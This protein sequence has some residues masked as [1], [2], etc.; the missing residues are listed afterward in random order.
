MRDLDRA[1]PA[2]ARTDAVPAADQRAGLLG[3]APDLQRVGAGENEVVRQG[4]RLPGLDDDR[5][6]GR[7]RRGNDQQ[8]AGERGAGERHRLYL[9]GWG[10]IRASG[11]A[12]AASGPRVADSEG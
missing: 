4:V 9:G 10:A 1:G 5:G 2:V 3:G 6:G 8:A 12:S 7:N 11:G